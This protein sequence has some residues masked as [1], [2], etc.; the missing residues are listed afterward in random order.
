MNLR[1]TKLRKGII[2]ETLIQCDSQY[3]SIQLLD[4]VF[5][6]YYQKKTIEIKSQYSASNCS[7]E[8]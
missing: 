7:L 6:E 4:I 5:C 8:L 1:Q 2:H 3:H